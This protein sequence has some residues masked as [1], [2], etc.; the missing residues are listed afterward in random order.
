MP[1]I[2]VTAYLATKGTTKRPVLSFTRGAAD[3]GP[4]DC[5]HALDAPGVSCK[6][7]ASVNAEWIDR[8]PGAA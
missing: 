3:A 1:P 5:Q 8:L 2:V 6:H 7:E 4:I